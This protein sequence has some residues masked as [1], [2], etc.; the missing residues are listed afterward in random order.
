MT[1]AIKWSFSADRCMRRCPRQF[2]LQDAVTALI[3]EGKLSSDVLVGMIEVHK[4]NSDGTRLGRSP[5][6]A[7]SGTRLWSMEDIQ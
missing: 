3:R 7:R 5:V 6:M 2:G 1:E 4:S